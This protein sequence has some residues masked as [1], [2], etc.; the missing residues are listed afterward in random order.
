MIGIECEFIKKNPSKTH[1]KTLKKTTTKKT[2]PGKRKE[3]LNKY[4]W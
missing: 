3:K 4:M 1:K 2:K